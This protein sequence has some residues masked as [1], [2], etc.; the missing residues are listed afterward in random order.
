MFVS[1]VNSR[2]NSPFLGLR[3]SVK[4][5]MHTVKSI[6]H[7]AAACDEIAL[8]RITL[9]TALT[10]T[11]LM[12]SCLFMGAKKGLLGLRLQRQLAGSHCML[13]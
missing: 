11:M 12:F 3:S 7:S 4:N 5:N 6:P 1:S 2:V 10:T 9:A 13:A 8:K